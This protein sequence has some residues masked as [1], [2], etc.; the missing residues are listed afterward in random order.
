MT[1]GRF[2]SMDHHCPWTNT[3]VG[4]SLRV[5]D[6]KQIRQFHRGQNFNGVAT[7]LAC[8]RQLET[9]GCFVLSLNSGQINLKAFVQFVHFVPLATFHSVR[10]FDELCFRKPMECIGDARCKRTFMH[11]LIEQWCGVCRYQR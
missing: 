6:S 4:L 9:R 5:A 8:L 10:S 1:A 11:F 7:F 3:C 2:C